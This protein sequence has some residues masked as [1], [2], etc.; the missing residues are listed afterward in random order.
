MYI[1]IV[2][3]DNVWPLI[4]IEITD[5]NNQATQPKIFYTEYKNALVLNT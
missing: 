5:N 1:I 3:Q 4:W 2:D